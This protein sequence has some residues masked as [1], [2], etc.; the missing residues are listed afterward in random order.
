MSVFDN[1]LLDGIRS[2]RMPSRTT[3]AR[4][5]Y[6]SRAQQ[7]TT[8]PTALMRQN[9]SKLTT[10][11]A[12]G[13]L[14]LFNYNPKTKADLP[15]YDTFP[16]VFPVKPAPKGFYGLNMHY[17]PYE[18]RAKLMDQLYSLSTDKNYD[19]NTKLQI[20]YDILNSTSKFKEFKP[21]FKRYL[22]SYVKSRPLQIAS[23]EWDIALFL[24][25]ER[26]QKA[27]KSQVWKD[28]RGKI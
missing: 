27:S 6:R 1:I 4:E 12:P 28:S 24:P 11:F 2:G 14:Y 21:T 8:T 13:N 3:Q 7:T 10:G 20:S 23:S 19:E 16:L 17:L 18:L 9:K 25:I 15:Y 5:W 26:F 22:S